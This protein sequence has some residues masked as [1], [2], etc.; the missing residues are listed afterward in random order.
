MNNNDFL[1]SLKYGNGVLVCFPDGRIAGR[2]FVTYGSSEKFVAISGATFYLTRSECLFSRKT[3]KQRGGVLAL[4]AY[5]ETLYQDHLSTLKRARREYEQCYVPSAER[6]RHN[7]TSN[8][9]GNAQFICEQN[10][11]SLSADELMALES[12]LGQL[13]TAEMQRRERAREAQCQG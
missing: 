4:A 9:L 2:A 8:I 1:S 12:I 7:I 13:K 10:L 6:L 3:G 5:D 11:N